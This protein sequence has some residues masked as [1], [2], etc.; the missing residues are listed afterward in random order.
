MREAVVKTVWER[1]NQHNDY[2]LFGSRE[3]AVEIS[4]LHP[5][6]VQ[7]FKLWQLYLDNVDPLLKVTHTPTL[8]VRII[9][10]ASNPSSLSPTLEALLFSI[11]CMSVLSLD[12]GECQTIFAT[13]RD[14]LLAKY[15][16]GC[17]QALLNCSFLRSS[18]RDCLTALLL[19]LVSVFGTMIAPFTNSRKVSVRSSTVPQSLSSMLGV[20]IRIAQRMGIHTE[21]VLTKS[22]PFEAEMCRRLWWALIL[23]DSRVGELADFRMPTLT[24]TWDCKIPLNLSDSDL[25]P[26]TEVPPKVRGISTDTLFAVVRGELGDFI[27]HARYHITSTNPALT[28]LAKDDSNSEGSELV[29]LEKMIEEKYLKHCDPGNPLHF[30]TMWMTRGQMAKC[31]LIEHHFRYSSLPSHQ[32]DEQ[33]NAAISCALDM[34]ECDTKLASSTLTK[35][36]QWILHLYF[37]FPAYIYV[38]QHL[39]RRPLSDQAAQAWD[40]MGDNYNA[41]FGALYKHD[42]FSRLFAKMVLQAWDIRETAYKEMGKTLEIPRLISSIREKAERT[43]PD[44][45]GLTT[46]PDQ[47]IE[48]SDIGFKDFLTPFPM[49]FAHQNPLHGMGGQHEYGEAGSRADTNASR[50]GPPNIDVHQLDWSAMDWDLIDTPAEGASVPY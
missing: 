47:P 41:R 23:F 5:E 21:A 28:S 4:T 48:P 11:Y 31:R 44:T 32:A 7:M 39:K 18:D 6:P 24:P 2:L 35:G 43:K 8:Q 50:L 37:P 14:D 1:L 12:L 29:R 13:E 38:V 17:R 40:V 27:R 15:Q 25:R 9:E 16:F 33:R 20:A 3:T 10:A 46:G 36:F 22:T 42:T 34:L 45:Q 49:G 30:I 19:Y 26:E